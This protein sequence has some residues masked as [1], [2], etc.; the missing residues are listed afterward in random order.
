MITITCIL[1]NPVL[2]A[3]P[4]PTHIVM[5]YTFSPATPGLLK[6]YNLMRSY[7]NILDGNFN[8]ICKY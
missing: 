7:G 1:E 3:P 8:K 5:H 6:I 2:P 4:L